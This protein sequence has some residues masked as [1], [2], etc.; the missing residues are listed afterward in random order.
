MQILHNLTSTREELIDV[1]DLDNDLYDLLID[2]DL[3]ICARYEAVQKGVRTPLIDVHPLRSP[4]G[5]DA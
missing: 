5:R 4:P 1:H 3:L 2:H